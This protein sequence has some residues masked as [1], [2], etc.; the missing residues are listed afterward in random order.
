M[1]WKIIMIMLVIAVVSGG[2]LYMHKDIGNPY[3][4]V[5]VIGSH[6]GANGELVDYHDDIGVRSIEDIGYKTGDKGVMYLC[7]GKVEI[8][9]T[10]ELLAEKKMAE[11]LKKIG[12]EAFR[13]KE[14][15]KIFFEYRGEKIEEWVR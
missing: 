6:I 3:A 15:G 1:K 13:N 2:V 14:T 8:E 12:I 9:L 4:L 5:D 10:P 11:K 7:Y